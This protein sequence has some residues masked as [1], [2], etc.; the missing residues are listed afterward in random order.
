[1]CHRVECSWV[2]MALSKVDHL[3]APPPP[4]FPSTTNG[5]VQEAADGAAEE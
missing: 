1:M 2:N 5:T 3:A 4:P